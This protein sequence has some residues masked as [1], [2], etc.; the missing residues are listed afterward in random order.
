MKQSDI[1][2]IAYKISDH[3]T[4]NEIMTLIQAIEE[5][6]NALVYALEDYWQA[7]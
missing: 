6:P 1:D 3:F 5:A 2:D 7:K 4:K